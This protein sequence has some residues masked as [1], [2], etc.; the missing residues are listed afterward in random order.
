LGE[1]VHDAPPLRNDVLL[2]LACGSSCVVRGPK[3]PPWACHRGLGPR[4]LYGLLGCPFLSLEDLAGYVVVP[5]A[6]IRLASCWGLS[7]WT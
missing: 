2:V 1:T 4:L 5:S 7:T 6:T 3:E